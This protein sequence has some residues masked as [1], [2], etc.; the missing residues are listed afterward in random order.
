MDH[1]PLKVLDALLIPLYLC[2][3]RMFSRV[4]FRLKLW[5]HGIVEHSNLLVFSC[6]SLCVYQFEDMG[7][8]SSLLSESEL[9]QIHIAF[10]PFFPYH[11]TGVA[12]IYTTMQNCVKLLNQLKQKS[13]PIFWD[14][15]MFRLVL[16]FYLKYPKE[17]M[18]LVPMLVGFHTARCVQRRTGKYIKKQV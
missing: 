12:I 18:N 11:V 14:E 9:P 3:K 15:G 7:W 4:F 17:F 16:N 2:L 5:C 1:C 6:I 10:L 8:D 13:L